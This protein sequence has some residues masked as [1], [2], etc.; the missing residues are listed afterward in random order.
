MELLFDLTFHVLGSII[1][2][3]FMVHGTFNDKDTRRFVWC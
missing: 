1:F 2:G 3:W